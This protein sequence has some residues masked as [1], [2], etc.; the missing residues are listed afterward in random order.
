MFERAVC[1]QR[2]GRLGLDGRAVEHV[3]S[4]L[5]EVERTLSYSYR[6]G[7]ANQAVGAGDV[8]I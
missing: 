5:L 4:M 7:P 2:W 6:N 8:A 3:G 1:L